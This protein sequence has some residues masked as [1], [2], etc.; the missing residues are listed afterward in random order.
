MSQGE[1]TSRDSEREIGLLQKRGLPHIFSITVHCFVAK[2]L[3][4]PLLPRHVEIRYFLSKIVKIALRAEK[5]AENGLRGYSTLCS[6]LSFT[7]IYFIIDHRIIFS[8]TPRFSIFPSLALFSSMGQISSVTIV[9]P[10]TRVTQVVNV[11]TP[12]ALTYFFSKT[13]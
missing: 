5:M 3:N 12:F 11:V 8:F 7:K 4:K 6:I 10:V 1:L 13:V 9:V 2:Q